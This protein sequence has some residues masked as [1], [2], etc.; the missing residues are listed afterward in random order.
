MR[1]PIVVVTN[2]FLPEIEARI[3]RQY[4]TRRNPNKTPLTCDDLLSLSEDADAI[5]MTSFDRLDNAFFARVSSSVKV[6]ATYSAGY[7]HIDVEAAAKRQIAIANT[8]GINS[9]AT[10]DV[11]MLL[12]LGA[13]RRAYEAQNLL[14]AGAWIPLSSAGAARPRVDRQNPGHCGHGTCWAS[15][16]KTRQRIRNGNP[17]HESRACCANA[18]G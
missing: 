13:S 2:H 9:N 6:I 15:S 1:K 14:R 11:T 10:A 3:D 4:V 18:R 5:F 17:L 16:R 8:P 7:E 12:I